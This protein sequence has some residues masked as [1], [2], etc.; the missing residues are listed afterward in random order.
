MTAT[1]KA[2]T[3]GKRNTV[4]SIY[5]MR[6]DKLQIIKTVQSVTLKQA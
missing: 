5:K 2:K 1:L 4:F 6:A 3:N